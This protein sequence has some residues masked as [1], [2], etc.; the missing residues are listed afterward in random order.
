MNSQTG[1]GL[2]PRFNRRSVLR[3]IL[4]ALAALAVLLA[5]GAAGTIWALNGLQASLVARARADMR[6]V[7]NAIEAYKSD[8]GAYPASTD[9]PA[10]STAG[11]G[12]IGAPSFRLRNT[13]VLATLTT[14][15]AYFTSYPHD[16][17]SHERSATFAYLGHGDKFLLWSAGPDNDHELDWRGYDWNADARPALVN[18]TYDPTNGAVS[19]GDIWR[20]ESAS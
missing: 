4:T 20:T 10:A 15:V 6:S 14:P 19:D 9:D 13:G 18:V 17:F 12:A 2:P 3:A 11:A 5:V 1:S 16:T 7:A 8:H